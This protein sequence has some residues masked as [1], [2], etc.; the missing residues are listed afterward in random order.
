MK[1]EKTV[2]VFSKFYESQQKQQMKSENTVKVFSNFMNHNKN[3]MRFIKWDIF[4][5]T[6]NK[7]LVHSL[8]RR[9]L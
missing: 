8:I 7:N 6:K 1:S 9:F 4:N 2:K 5:G 3:S